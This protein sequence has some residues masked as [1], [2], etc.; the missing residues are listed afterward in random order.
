MGEETESRP[1]VANPGRADRPPEQSLEL[2]IGSPPQR[3]PDQPANKATLQT[4]ILD[5]FKEFRRSV[6]LEGL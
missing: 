1:K 6:A 3:K 5:T 2:L 4:E